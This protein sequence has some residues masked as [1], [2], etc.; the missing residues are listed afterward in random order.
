[1]SNSITQ[2]QQPTKATA[3]PNHTFFRISRAPD[4]IPFGGTRSSPGYL[5]F[6]GHTPESLLEFIIS[7]TYKVSWRILNRVVFDFVVSHINWIVDLH[8]RGVKD[9]LDEWMMKG[10]KR[11]GHIEWFGAHYIPRQLRHVWESRGK[12]IPYS[13]EFRVRRSTIASIRT[14]SP[15]GRVE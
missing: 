12:S 11:A 9:E 1:M 4:P 7:E 6:T 15:S 13:V 3:I 5:A 14:T 10:L 2:Q 8:Y